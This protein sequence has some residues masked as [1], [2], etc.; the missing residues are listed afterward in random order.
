MKRT[1]WFAR[2]FAPI[3]D[4][5]IFPCIIERL[6]GTHL[7]LREKAENIA[8][9]SLSKAES[10]GWSI[11]KEIGHLIDLEPLWLARVE[12]FASE[13]EELTPAD[14]TNKKTHEADHDERETDD[15]LNEFKNQR[16][17]LVKK[18]RSL[19]DENLNR[20]LLH[21]RL[22]TPMRVIDLTF[23]VAE[24]DDHHL[25][26]ITFLIAGNAENYR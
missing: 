4:N 17:I 18:L 15:L 12:D 2:K 10:G 24:H 23:F 22:K 6:E 16:D 11:K 8:P 14:L 25:A 19:N 1:K 5:G 26:K 13:K 3:E 21:P 9:G 20:S 7:R